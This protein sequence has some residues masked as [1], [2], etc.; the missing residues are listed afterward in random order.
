MK[1]L[2]ARRMKQTLDRLEE[3]YLDPSEMADPA[4]SDPELARKLAEGYRDPGEQGGNSTACRKIV[5]VKRNLPFFGSLCTCGEAMQV[6]KSSFF[7]FFFSCLFIG[8]TRGAQVTDGYSDSGILG[9][10]LVASL[11]NSDFGQVG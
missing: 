6:Y 11:I 9:H 5:F 1:K 8:C 10:Y 3:D 2:K 7:F 4:A